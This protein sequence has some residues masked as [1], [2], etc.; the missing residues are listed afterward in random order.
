MHVYIHILPFS[1][2]LGVS[3]GSTFVSESCS[4]GSYLHVIS[5][6]EP[7]AAAKESIRLCWAGEEAFFRSDAFTVTEYL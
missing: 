3:M 1:S 5:G 4:P 6:S 7:A 2:A